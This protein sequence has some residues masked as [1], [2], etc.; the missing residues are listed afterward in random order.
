MNTP[1]SPE[2][3]RARA[4]MLRQQITGVYMRPVWGVRSDARDTALAALSS[5]ST[6]ALASITAFWWMDDEDD[7]DDGPSYEITETGVALIPVHGV[8][9]DASS[10]WWMRYCGYGS[11]PEIAQMVTD[12]ANDANVTAILLHVDSPG[13]QASGVALCAEAVAMARRESGK[14]VIAFC[15]EACSAAY[16][17]ASQAGRVYVPTDGISGCIGTLTV[18]SDWSEYYAQ[19]G[20]RKERITS[21]GAEEHK[22]QG[23]MGTVLT[24]AQKADFKRVC[25]EF[26]ALFSAAVADGRNLDAAAVSTL[27][28]G[29]WHVGQNG[30]SL[31]L[32]DDVTT[33][34]ELLDLL[35]S[36]EVL[37]ENADP[38]IPPGMPPPDEDDH[39]NSFRQNARNFSLSLR[40][41]ARSMF[42]GNYLASE[43]GAQENQA[44]NSLLPRRNP[45]AAASGN[46]GI[47]LEMYQQLDAD[48]TA[49]RAEN[50]RL[51]ARFNEALTAIRADATAAAVQAFGQ[52]TQD[53]KDAAAAIAAQDSP[54]ALRS[55]TVAYNRL[56]PAAVANPTGERTT[57][58]ASVTTTEASAPPK[59][60]QEKAD[61]DAFAKAGEAA[62]RRLGLANAN[63]GGTR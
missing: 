3:V 47:T 43:A 37:Y 12:A 11:T 56:R 39:P 15:P 38:Q 22:G 28:D 49:L 24:D 62:A 25:N 17:I 8:L 45:Q 58:A 16:W 48:L 50:E 10:S 41:A 30:V 27:A 61:D 26:Q 35:G 31:G 21:D 4:A 44:M 57:E 20:V 5:L 34:D 40:N 9:L 6:D 33:Y 23:A 46:G 18:L 51:T 36:G 63:H 13:G 29:R 53:Y 19:M 55:L 54:S 59:E 42:G 32:A 7:D 60:Q 2:L 52:E 14:Q 1:T